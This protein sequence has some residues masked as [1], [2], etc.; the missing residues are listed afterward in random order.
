VIT[1][2]K[3]IGEMPDLTGIQAVSGRFP[4]LLMAPSGQARM[5]ELTTKTDE[6]AQK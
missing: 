6:N 1:D 2:P 3:R 5:K 4:H